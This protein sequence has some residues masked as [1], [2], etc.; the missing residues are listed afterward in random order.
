MLAS[1]STAASKVKQLE[2]PIDDDLPQSS[3]VQT[4]ELM[5]ASPPSATTSNES[6]PVLNPCTDTA[7]F[8]LY[9]V[10]QT[11]HCRDSTSNDRYRLPMS[12]LP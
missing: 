3:G 5:T 10:S 4:D 12:N 6:V 11:S 7:F 2:G 8:S 1:Y 9:R